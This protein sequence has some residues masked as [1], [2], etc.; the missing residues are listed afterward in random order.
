MKKYIYIVEGHS[1][2]HAKNYKYTIDWQCERLRLKD[3]K[4]LS[5][6]LSYEFLRQNVVDN[7]DHGK[8]GSELRLIFMYLGT[9]LIKRS[10]TVPLSIFFAL[11][12]SFVL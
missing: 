6:K 8:A 11:N 10:V 4:D 12:M 5:L 3:I 9:L 7:F 1:Q 2:Q